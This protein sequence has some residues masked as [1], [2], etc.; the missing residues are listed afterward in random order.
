MSES[1]LAKKVHERHILVRRAVCQGNKGFRKI[2][3]PRHS[4]QN[5][6]RKQGHLGGGEPL[7]FERKK[8]QHM[9]LKT[10]STEDKFGLFIDLRSMAGQAMQG[11]GIES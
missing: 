3:L 6:D 9:N 2:H 1:Q 11:S 5:W 8:K 10:F 4:V 7:P